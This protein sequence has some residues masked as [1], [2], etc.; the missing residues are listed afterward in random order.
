[1]AILTVAEIRAEGITVEIASDEQVEDAIA[2]CTELFNEQT[3]QFFEPLAGEIVVDGDNTDSIFLFIPIIEVTSITDNVTGNVMSATNYRAYTGR[4]RL[5]N[6]RRNPKIMAKNGYG[7][8]YGPGRWTIAGTFGY[9]E[10][11]G[12]PPVAVK[13]A[14]K[15]LTIEMLLHP[16]VA[17]AEILPEL[18]ESIVDNTKTE[19]VTD[20]HKIKW[21]ASSAAPWDPLAAISASPFVRKAIRDY[22]KPF[23]IATQVQGFRFEVPVKIGFPF[24]DD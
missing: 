3:G 19:E 8:S 15:I 6:D 5:Q 4:T 9:T 2:F 13:H 21:S 1:M 24:E 22:R 7:F 14:I 17:P 18:G 10:S 11:D 12:S 20:D 16:I 23:G